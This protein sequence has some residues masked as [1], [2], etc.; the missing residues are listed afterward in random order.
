MF[1]LT[2]ISTPSL[3]SCYVLVLQQ[4]V[5]LVSI[6]PIPDSIHILVLV[7]IHPPLLPYIILWCLPCGTGIYFILQSPKTWF[8]CKF[9][10]INSIKLTDWSGPYLSSV[11]PCPPLMEV[12]FQSCVFFLGLCVLT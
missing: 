11:F 6:I 8:G 12:D 9:S 4:I 5:V 2:K 1:I 10:L 7:N 3:A